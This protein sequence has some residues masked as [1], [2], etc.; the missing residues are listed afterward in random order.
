MAPKDLDIPKLKPE[1]TGLNLNSVGY[2]LTHG[3]ISNT[4]AMS[5]APT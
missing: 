1:K 5:A 4:T 2:T 3:T